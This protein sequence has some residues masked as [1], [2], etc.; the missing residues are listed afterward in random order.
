MAREKD[1]RAPLPDLVETVFFNSSLDTG[2][3]YNC[4]RCG[5][6]ITSSGISLEDRSIRLIKII[7]VPLIRG[8]L[9]SYAH[10]DCEGPMPRLWGK[11]RAAE[12]RMRCESC[13]H[14]QFSSLSTSIVPEIYPAGTL[15][16]LIPG[17]I[18]EKYDKKFKKLDRKN[19][20]YSSGWC[21]INPD[22]PTEASKWVYIFGYTS[23]KYPCTLGLN[24][25][26]E[27][28][29]FSGDYLPPIDIREAD[30]QGFKTGR[31]R[32]KK[33]QIEESLDDEGPSSQH[34]SQF[35]WMSS[36]LSPSKTAADGQGEEEVNW[37]PY[38]SDIATRNED[39]AS[40]GDAFP[41]VAIYDDEEERLPAD[42]KLEKEDEN[43]ASAYV[44]WLA[45]IR[46]HPDLGKKPYPCR[47][48]VDPFFVPGSN[49]RNIQ[50]KRF[51]YMEPVKLVYVG[52]DGIAKN[53]LSSNL[54][55]CDLQEF[56]LA[57]WMN[58]ARLRVRRQLKK[59]PPATGAELNPMLTVQNPD[60]TD[61][62][63]VDSKGKTHST[64]YSVISWIQ[65]C[66]ENARHTT[67]EES[68]TVIFGEW[69]A[70]ARMFSDTRRNDVNERPILPPS[71]IAEIA[72]TADVRI[73]GYRNGAPVGPGC[74][75]RDTNNGDYGMSW[76]KLCSSALF[77]VKPKTG[78]CGQGK[79]LIE[80]FT[81]VCRDCR[82]QSLKAG[83]GFSMKLGSYQNAA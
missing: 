81:A 56:V 58:E 23:D 1:A 15:V 21:C 33:P 46:L 75:H 38:L 49:P 8:E 22:E 6:L 14:M 65:E 77:P 59:M 51:P 17:G 43:T 52:R 35:D 70:P 55:G 67:P 76:A 3:Y 13:P 34:E 69:E 16:E 68:T 40:L 79:H 47:W 20:R 7:R 24:E 10:A 66:I 2:N 28:V 82:Y 74:S 37:F 45:K 18:C 63:W 5:E 11:V 71:S 39:R 26:L 73:V 54:H 61:R 80:P 50:P 53:F 31:R 30:S 83:L 62:K 64:C 41:A 29:T 57:K 36:R 4:A 48:W 25:Q 60:G 32:R 44:R 12:D 19:A 27:L 72:R 78:K 42:L 9:Y